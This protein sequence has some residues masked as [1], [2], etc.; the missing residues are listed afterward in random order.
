MIT[1]ASLSS[2][3]FLRSNET[4]DCELRI[5]FK[6]ERKHM[7]AMRVRSSTTIWLDLTWLDLTW[8]DP[9][10][11]DSTNISFRSHV[12][13]HGNSEKLV[14]QTTGSYGRSLVIYSQLHTGVG[15]EVGDE[16]NAVSAWDVKRRR[17]GMR[18]RRPN[19][20][21]RVDAGTGH[22]FAPKYARCIYRAHRRHRVIG[23]EMYACESCSRRNEA[24]SSTSL[25]IYRHPASE[26]LRGG[27]GYII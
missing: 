3:Q 26:C 1:Q 5:N 19:Q 16:D 8:L 10:K 22:R 2:Y 14:W 12:P 25:H 20:S 9:G 7:L 13:W 24:G 23:I 11:Q 6:R 17:R 15:F 18:T 27:E 4:S 21:F